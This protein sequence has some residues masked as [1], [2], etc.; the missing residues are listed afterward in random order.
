MLETCGAVVLDDFVADRFRLSDSGRLAL[1][2]GEGKVFLVTHGS[3]DH[4]PAQPVARYRPARSANTR[5][6]RRA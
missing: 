5:S 6:A 1:A 2:G 4:R 3:A